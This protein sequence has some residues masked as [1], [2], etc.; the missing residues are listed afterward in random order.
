MAKLF[1]ILGF[2]VLALVVLL[3]AFGGFV[4]MR[5]NARMNQEYAFT[6]STL[7]IPTD[8]ASVATGDHLVHAVFACVG[9]HGEDLGG[10]MVI[11]SPVMARIA[12]PNLTRGKGGLAPGY[13][14]ADYECAIRHGVRR[15][16]RPII[17]MPSEAY[18]YLSDEELQQVAAYLASVPPVD[19][20]LP[21]VKLGP[22]G[23]MLIA[24][25]QFLPASQVEHESVGRLAKAPTGTG[26][27]RGEHL[28][29][30]CVCTS[31]HGP[32]L[33]GGKA[34]G[35]DPSWPPAANLTPHEEGLGNVT[36]QQF[37]G[38]LR[39]GVK[40]NGQQLDAEMMPWTSYARMSDDEM[41]ALWAYL[42][43]LP[44]TPTPK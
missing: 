40:R 20:S 4:V 5:S 18:A 15:D 36:F 33:A 39:T 22:I 28:A 25:G 24:F 34:A 19:R 26:P 31:C 21:P 9:C 7:S 8:S 6:P 11:D 2:V 1:R 13:T 3:V 32:Q 38:I 14:M 16:H 42:Q 41:H 27:D 35:G 30:V 23:S 43:T 12:A 37:E 29:K 17:L 10:K 44:P